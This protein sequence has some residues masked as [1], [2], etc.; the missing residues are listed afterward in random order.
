MP[1]RVA[2]IVLAAASGVLAAPPAPAITWADWIGDWDAKLKWSSC[3]ADGEDKATLSID[4]ADG[5]VS[6]DLRP[7]GA[8]LPAMSLIE[9]GA[10]WSG[11]QGDVSVRVRRVPAGKAPDSLELAIDLD[12]GCQVR[13]TLARGSVGIPACDRL[14]AWARIESQCSRLARPPLEN[15]A[16]LA[17]QREQWKK[18]TGTMREK[19][20][21]QCTARSAKVEA[22][23]VDNG[24]APHTDPAIGLRG[25]ECQALRR[26]SS[27]IARCGSIP[28]DLRATLEKEAIVLAAASQ[29]A[30]KAALPI[31][32]GECKSARDKLVTIAKQAG[33]PP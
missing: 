2:A 11:Q 6:I 33:C 15:H 29:G 8:A 32:E 26:E 3:A 17:R 25:A 23:M 13:G 1:R 20:A 28:F 19:L 10:A 14:A 5:V 30:D 31:V 12:S 7:A 16:R 9:D 21:A 18:A 24:C 4:A 22:E 27:R